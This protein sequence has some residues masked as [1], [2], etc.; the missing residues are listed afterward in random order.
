M[1]PCWLLFQLLDPVGDR[2]KQSQWYNLFGQSERN[3]F[4]IAGPTANCGINHIF[5]PCK[6]TA[7]LTVSAVA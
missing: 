4:G 2:G 5:G 3:V 6:T 7:D 1:D